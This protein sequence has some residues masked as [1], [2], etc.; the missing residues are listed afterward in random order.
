MADDFKYHIHHHASLVVP[1]ELAQA[2][3]AG[4][5]EAL[6]QAVESAI[7]DVLLRQ[8]RLA[9]SA[10]SDGEF[11]RRNDLAVA[12]DTIEGF[13]EP[14]AMTPLAE[15]V[16]P[17]HAAEVRR[18]VGTPAARGRLAGQE[19]TQ[20]GALTHRSTMVALP[21]AGY[22][23]ALTAPGE[24][25][26]ALAAIIRAEIEALAADGVDYVLLRNP[27]F[28]FL[29]TADGRASAQRLGIDPDKTVATMHAAESAAVADLDVPV[30][31]RVGLDLTTAGQARGPW[32][33]AAVR[34]FLAAQPFG[35]LCVDFPVDD[36]FPLELVP[37]GLVMSLGVVDIAG[38]ALED[39]D[40]LVD[41]IDEAAKVMDV[42]DIAISTNGGFHVVGAA[43]AEY[44]HA[45]LQRVEMVARYFW[46]NEL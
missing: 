38:P 4:D 26:G 44:E 9:L 7:A 19:G 40:A 2:R 13:G 24:D 17:A 27:A 43:A 46:G 20:L 34:E 10:L 32:D 29:L 25:G 33:T 23:A 31:F 21:S 18:L 6:A 42:D 5:E 41:R 39:V 22:L 15:L 8:R 30:N 36:H 35:R 3:T 28:A 1:A 11:R 14:G 12:Y 16:G 45:K 37:A